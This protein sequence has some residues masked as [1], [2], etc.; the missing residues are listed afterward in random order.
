FQL[1]L[2]QTAA[3]AAH[4]SFTITFN[5]DTVTWDTGAGAAPAAVGF[6]A[7]DGAPGHDYI[8]PGSFTRG[9]LLDGDAATGLIH[10]SHDSGGQLGRYVFSVAGGG[11]GGRLSK[12]VY[13]SD[14]ATPI[15][16][17]PVQICRVGRACV[18]RSTNYAGSYVAA[19]LAP[20]SY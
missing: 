4:G 10:N 9:A 18:T 15:A 17:A 14:F 7:G 13:R 2:R 12:H 5:Y 19:G 8:Q 16:F 11:T 6:S 20:G 1:V 3:E